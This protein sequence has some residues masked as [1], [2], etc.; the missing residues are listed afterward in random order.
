MDLKLAGHQ[1]AT[2][3]EYDYVQTDLELDGHHSANLK[4][5]I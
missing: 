2:L 5:E 3:N 1:N 4:A